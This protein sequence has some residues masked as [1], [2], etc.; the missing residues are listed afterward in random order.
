MKKMGWLLPSLHQVSHCHD[1]HLAVVDV[2][3]KRHVREDQNTD[4][5]EE[6]R[7]GHDEEEEEEAE[8]LWEEVAEQ[9]V[10]LSD[11]CLTAVQKV[12][13]IVNCFRK[14]PLKNDA[15]QE[16]CILEKGKGLSLLRD[17]KTQWNSLLKML[18][19]FLAM[20]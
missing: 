16:V 4:Q 6:S 12:Q 3:Y 11:D 2:L 14:S 10:E 17:T 9:E 20:K 1:L 15:L 7:E 19:R 18:Q 8:D 5:E 13:K